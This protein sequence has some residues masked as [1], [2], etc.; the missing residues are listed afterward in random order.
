MW[1]EYELYELIE[2]YDTFGNLKTDYELIEVI[3]V[4]LAVKSMVVVQNDQVYQ[5]N[6]VVATTPYQ[7]LLHSAKYKL[8]RNDH[9]YMIESF[10]EGRICSLQLK[11]VF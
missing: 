7:G 6:S 1:S 2:S 3:D 8:K 9:E 5:V 11:E 4:S 10:V